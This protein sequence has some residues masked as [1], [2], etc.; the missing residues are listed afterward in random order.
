MGLSF[1]SWPITAKWRLS[2][3]F[4]TRDDPIAHVSVLTHGIDVFNVDRYRRFKAANGG[5]GLHITG[6]FTGCMAIMSSSVI[7]MATQDHWV[8]AI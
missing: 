2:S 6:R 7:M 5:Y 8:W 1:F 3:R 4:G